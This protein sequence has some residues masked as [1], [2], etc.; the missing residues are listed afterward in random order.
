V[1]NAN[2]GVGL[3]GVFA[4]QVGDT[5]ATP[6]A[7]PGNLI[8]GNPV[9]ISAGSVS[10]LT[11]RGNLVGTTANGLAALANPGG[12][13]Q[14]TSQSNGCVIGGTA[15]GDRNVVSGNNPGTGISINDSSSNQ[16]LGNFVGTDATGNA[17]L[18][19]NIGITVFRT[20]LGSSATIG[21]TGAAGR[22]VVSGNVASGIV[23]GG[24]GTSAWILGNYIGVGADGVTPLGNTADGVRSVDSAFA[25]VGSTTGTTPGFCTGDCN[26]I[27]YNAGAGVRVS[28]ALSRA[29]MRRNS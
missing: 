1:P 9:G 12:G 13:I 28:E 8:S 6:G 16:I 26:L 14:L 4:C 19:N 5:T 11:I 17:A 29:S 2:T 24:L 22:N 25:F 23:V 15:S 27:A 10:S 18:P 21:G 20:A 3:A 7:A